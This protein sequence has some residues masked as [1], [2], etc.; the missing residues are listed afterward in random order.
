M[1]WARMLSC[2]VLF[3]CS[4]LVKGQSNKNDANN[5]VSSKQTQEDIETFI[6][7]C[8]TGD[9]KSVQYAIKNGANVTARNDK[10]NF[11]LF[12]AVLCNPN[13]DVISALINAGANSNCYGSKAFKV[14]LVPAVLSAK[15]GD[16][17][18]VLAKAGADP[19]FRTDD[20][21]TPLLIAASV[22]TND[23]VIKSLIKA[24]ADIEAKDNK[25]N[26][27]L[28][29]AAWENSNPKVI[30]ELVKAGADIKGGSFRGTGRFNFPTLWA[31][32]NP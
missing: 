29:T 28:M 1:K 22:N 20:N 4:D 19:N 16:V 24:G 21:K 2:F 31:L 5:G 12:T 8:S 32:Q 11:P 3:L 18:T 7:L 25:G 6:E 30:N 23:S 10:G 14:L 26:T 17:I 9:V 13:A 27:A 15:S